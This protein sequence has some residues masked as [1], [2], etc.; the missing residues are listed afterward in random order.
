MPRHLKTAVV[1]LACLA[2]C[3]AVD[4][5]YLPGCAA[6]AGDRIELR[7]DTFAWDKFTDAVEI[8]DAGNRVDAFPG[9]PK[10]GS[11]DIDGDR[12]VLRFDDGAET[13]VLHL[14]RSSGSLELL[15]DTQYVAWKKSNNYP[16]CVLARVG[17]IE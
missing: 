7:G 16:D 10:T 6:Y 2:G 17:N 3:K 8:D 5:T 12:L 4:G 13:Q 1:I 14:Q 9:Y 15:T 11:F